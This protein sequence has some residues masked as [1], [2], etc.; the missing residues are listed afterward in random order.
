M[1]NF[2]TY[3]NT[4][5]LKQRKTAFLCSRQCPANIILKTYDWAIEQREQGKCVISGFHSRIEKDVLRFLI[6]G[7]QPIIIALAR[8]MKKRWEPEIRKAVS[9]KRLLVITPF[10]QSVTWITRKTAFERNRFMA[11]L[12]HEIFIPHASPGG[13]LEKLVREISGEKITT[14]KTSEQI[15]SDRFLNL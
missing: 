14:I 5:I 2:F 8:G 1:E 7:E 13:N 10:A 4:E 11:R 12:A 9:Q 3:G 6:K 15:N